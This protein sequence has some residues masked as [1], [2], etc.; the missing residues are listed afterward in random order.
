MHMYFSKTGF[1]H[2]LNWMQ[3]RLCTSSWRSF[4]HLLALPSPSLVFL[5]GQLGWALLHSKPLFWS[6]SA[7]AFLPF[8]WMQI[9]WNITLLSQYLMIADVMRYYPR[10]TKYNISWLVISWNIRLESEYLW[11]QILWDTSQEL[12][13]LIVGCIFSIISIFW[14]LQINSQSL[15]DTQVEYISQKYT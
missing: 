10:T 5:F 8:P 11:L 14:H 12:Q 15:E 13:Y 7:L 6:S 9:L 2:L 3:P 4:P 1:V